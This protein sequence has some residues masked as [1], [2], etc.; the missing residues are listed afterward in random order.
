[1]EGRQRIVLIASGAPGDRAALTESLSLD[2]I[3]RYRVIAAETGARALEICQARIPDCLILDRDLPDLSGL[4]V[5]RSLAAEEGAP[6][7]AIVALT[8]AGD[9]RFAVEAMKNG[10]HDC[11]ERGLAG[12][13]ELRRAVYRAIKKAE[14]RRRDAEYGRELIEKN[15]ALESRLD[16]QARAAG[17]RGERAWQVAGA[18]AGT[19]GSTVARVEHDG[20]GPAQERLRLLN[21][22]IEQSDESVIITTAQLYP[23]GPQIVYVNPAFT[24]MTG[25]SPEEALGQT[26]CILQGTKTEPSVLDRLRSDCAAGKIFHGEANNR[27]KDGSEFYTEWSVGPVTLV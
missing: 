16:S 9:L 19:G 15:R 14:R 17:G 13:A 12:G 23:P 7:C 26:P 25:Y 1:M 24:R 10:A 3:A 5:L 11:L 21:A 18:G 8:G 22:A 27:R 6:A 20:R 2:S 4:D